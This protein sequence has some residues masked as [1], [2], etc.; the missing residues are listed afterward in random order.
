MK[1]GRLKNSTNSDKKEY[2]CAIQFIHKLE[3]ADP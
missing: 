2:A 1:E 3:I